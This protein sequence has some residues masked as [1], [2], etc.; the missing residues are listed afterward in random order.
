VR[1]S[2]GRR[3]SP[4]AHAFLFAVH[5]ARVIVAVLAALLLAVPAAQAAVPKSSARALLRGCERGLEQSDRAAIFEGQMRSAPGVSRMQ[6]RFTLQARESAG[7]RW[8]AVTAP[9]FGTWVG[10]ATGTYRYIYTKRV[11]ALLAP[12]QYRVLLRFRWLASSGGVLARARAYSRACR[13]PDPRADLSVRSL[14]VQPGSRQGRSRYVAYVRNTGRSAA[15]PTTLQLTV[16]GELLPAVAV[17]GLEP[18]EGALVSVEGAS[19]APGAPIDAD[20]DADET[21]DEADE[22]DNRLSR[23]C[24][25][26]F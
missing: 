19:C 14:G 18:G 17:A 13:Q 9:G 21:V 3:N 22:A 25:E 16:D 1:R 11:E 2:P 12:A 10:S 26:P 5:L 24:P 6:M 8:V 15:E 7:D 4:R 23:I 20:A